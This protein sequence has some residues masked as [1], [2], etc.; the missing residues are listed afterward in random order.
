MGD[1]KERKQQVSE[2]DDLPRGQACGWGTAVQGWAEGFPV[3]IMA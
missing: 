2:M 1:G 3:F